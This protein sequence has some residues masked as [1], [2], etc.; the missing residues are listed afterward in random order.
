VVGLRRGSDGLDD[1]AGD[2][3][4]INME[5][6]RGTDACDLPPPP[7]QLEDFAGIEF[8]VDPDASRSGAK[9]PLDLEHQVV[10]EISSH[11]R[12]ILPEPAREHNRQR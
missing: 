3:P 2:N 5:R 12:R 9:D 4:A 1:L 6:A 7:V 10:A 8:P 11:A